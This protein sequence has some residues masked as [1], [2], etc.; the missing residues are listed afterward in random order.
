MAR[1]PLDLA[2]VNLA[3]LFSD[4]LLED[5]FNLWSDLSSRSDDRHELPISISDLAFDRSSIAKIC[6]FDGEVIA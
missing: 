3:L 6:Y 2:A 1:I 4:H 5:E